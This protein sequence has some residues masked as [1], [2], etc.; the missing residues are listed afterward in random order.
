M[1]LNTHTFI[2]R[3]ASQ[4]WTSL[5]ILDLTQC[6]HLQDSDLAIIIAH[7]PRIRNLVLY[8]CTS[9]TDR[10]I[11]SLVTLG[12]YLHYLHLGHCTEITDLSVVQ[13][14]RHCTRLR[15]LDLASC[16]R[17]TDVSCLELGSHLEK[18]KRIGLVKCVNVSDAGICSL[19]RGR[20]QICAVLERIHLS[21][22]T[23]LTL[24]VNTLIPFLLTN[25]FHDF[26]VKFLTMLVYNKYYSLLST[27][28]AY[29]SLG[30]PGVFKT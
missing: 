23:R 15:Y 26:L 2:P 17:I 13:L 4:E 27:F 22:C 3:I 1:S 21:Y 18:L 19:V 8:K 29:Q 9:L 5:R 14:A 30:D 20:A 11:L 16:I 12:K 24:S 6:S 25:I 7:A 10:G 28:N